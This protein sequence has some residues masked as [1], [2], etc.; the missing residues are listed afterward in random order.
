MFMVLVSYSESAT[1]RMPARNEGSSFA[2]SAL[3]GSEMCPREVGTGIGV[4]TPRTARDE[5]IEAAGSGTCREGRTFVII[6]SPFI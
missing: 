5:F 4:G 6:V 2:R 3:I 1:R